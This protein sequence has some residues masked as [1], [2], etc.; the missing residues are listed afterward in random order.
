MSLLFVLILIHYIV[1]NLSQTTSETECSAMDAYLQI[2]MPPV[3]FNVILSSQALFPPEIYRIQPTKIVSLLSTDNSCNASGIITDVNNTIVLL[4]PSEDCTMQ[5]QV[6][7]LQTNGAKAVI[8]SSFDNAISPI[9]GS[10]NITT[11]IPARQIRKSDAEFIVTGMQN[12]LCIE[13]KDI[14]HK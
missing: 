4:Y 14:I 13:C 12:I 6:Y 9:L 5:Y 7:V 8:F 3:G 2:Q 1:L 10:S 11:T